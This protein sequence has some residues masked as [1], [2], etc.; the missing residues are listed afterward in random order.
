MPRE[1]RRSYFIARCLH[2]AVTPSPRR[3]IRNARGIYATFALSRERTSTF[4]RVARFVVITP[5]ERCHSCTAMCRG[6]A[7]PFKNPILKESE[8][9]TN[10]STHSHYSSRHA[11]RYKFYSITVNTKFRIAGYQFSSLPASLFVKRFFYTVST[12]LKYYYK[13][14]SKFVLKRNV[15]I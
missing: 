9:M 11:V 1:H 14:N 3:G 13:K 15:E 6:S 10:R 4:L 12:L 8:I 5:V 2:R 7:K